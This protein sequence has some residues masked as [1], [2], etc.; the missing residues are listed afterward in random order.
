V[1]WR[2]AFF[3]AALSLPLLA[4]LAVGLR[5]DPRSHASPLPGNPA[6]DFELEKLPPPGV[7]AAEPEMVRLS[8]HLGEVVVL[9]FWASWCVSCMEEHEPMSA[10]AERYE[11][12]GV[13]FYGVLY[14]DTP[15]AAQRFLRRFGEKSYPTLIDYRSRI[16]ITYGL[17]GVPETFFIA[18]D[19]RVAYRHVGPTTASLLVQRIEA[20]LAQHAADADS[21][22]PPG[23]LVPPPAER[24]QA[25][26][27]ACGH[28]AGSRKRGRRRSSRIA[29]PPSTASA[30]P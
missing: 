20:M 19:G 10:V 5:L 18:P 13:R 6:P 21:P 28:R 26:C 14:Q 30:S 9:N 17:R 22:D 4:I 8:D 29:G 2:R 24:R 15:S 27:R 25:P 1:N 7:E 3:A 12:R 11:G 16:A 23:A